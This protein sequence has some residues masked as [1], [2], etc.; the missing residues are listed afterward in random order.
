MLVQHGLC[1]SPSRQ[2]C[3]TTG[4]H[5]YGGSRTHGYCSKCYEKGKKISKKTLLHKVSV[6]I[7]V[8]DSKGRPFK[9]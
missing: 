3:K 4:C 6:L 7:H 5:Y 8:Y 2:R 1:F 9:Y